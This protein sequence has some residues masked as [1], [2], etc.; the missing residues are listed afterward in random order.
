MTVQTIS[1][2]TVYGVV[3]YRMDC[4]ACGAKSGHDTEVQAVAAARAHGKRKHS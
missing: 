3:G 4:Q 1:E 2:T